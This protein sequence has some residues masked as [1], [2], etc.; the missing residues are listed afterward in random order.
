MFESVIITIGVIDTI[1]FFHLSHFSRYF[2]TLKHKAT[3][4]QSLS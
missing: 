2:H 1:S 3:V 4:P